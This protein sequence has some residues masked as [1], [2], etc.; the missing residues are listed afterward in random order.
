MLMNS[1]DPTWKHGGW[2]HGGTVA[3]VIRS[4]FIGIDGKI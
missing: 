3:H 1:P 4:E 2:H